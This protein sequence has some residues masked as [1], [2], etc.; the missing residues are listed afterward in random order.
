M[1]AV[2]PLVDVFTGNMI[3]LLRFAAAV[4]QDIASFLLA[5]RDD[6][7]QTLNRRD[8]TDARR[9]RVQATLSDTQ[10]AIRATYAQIATHTDTMLVA[11][12]TSEVAYVPAAINASLGVSVATKVVPKQALATLVTDSLVMGSPLS[13][14]WARQA[15]DT[16][17]RALSQVRL[18]VASGE[19]TPQIVRRIV[20]TAKQPGVLAAS[21]REAQTLVRTAVAA[22]G[23]SAQ[24]AAYQANRDIFKGYE[25]VSVMDTRTSEICIAYSGATWDLDY[26]PT[27]KNDLPFNGGCPR[28]PNCR[29][30]IVPI[31]K[32]WRELGVNIDELPEGTRATMDGPRRSSLTFEEWLREKD[33]GVQNA[34]LGRGKAEL[35]RSGKISLRDLLDQS[36][37]PLTLADLL[38]KRGQAAP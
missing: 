11:L 21:F 19:T 5:L 16:E 4:E 23:N 18:G 3:D 28:H 30:S 15:G 10:D 17:L 2:D 1:P 9:A 25:Q 34:M 29:S 38:K 36:G 8:L 13:A 26:R 35:W 24:L 20:G 27:G 37:R 32:T 31:I 7:I 14:W 22:I 12:A 6:L 33:E